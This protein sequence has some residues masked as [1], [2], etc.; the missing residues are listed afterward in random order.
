M[1]YR[2]RKQHGQNHT[3]GVKCGHQGKILE[4]NKG[5]SMCYKQYYKRGSGHDN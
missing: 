1:Y 5:K 4:S 3:H 2:S